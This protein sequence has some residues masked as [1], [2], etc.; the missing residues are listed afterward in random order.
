[1]GQNCCVAAKDKTLPNNISHET[2]TYRNVRQSP[3]WNFRW[4]NRTH[5]E[6]I[7]ENHARC[8]HNNS[9]NVTSEV[10]SVAD[11]ESDGLSDSENPH[12]AFQ[13]SQWRKSPRIG[14]S[15]NPKFIATDQS[16]ACNL[17][18]EV[19]NSLKS[20]VFPNASDIESSTALP[21]SSPPPL[22]VEDP[23]SSTSGGFNP[24][25][26]NSSRKSIRSPGFQLY[27]QISDSR[28]P[29]LKSLN[30]GSSSPEAGRLS[31]V[32]GN[33]LSIE[34]HGV[35]SD[36]WSMHTFS[37]LIAS[38]QRD[39]SSLTNENLKISELNSQPK[40]NHA[41]NPQT[42]GI[43]SKLLKEKSPWSA[44]K[45]VSTN[46]LPI[47]AVLVCGHVFHAECLESSTSETDMYDPPC[48]VC[49]NNVERHE[50]RGRNRI[51]RIV[52]VDADVDSI[53]DRRTRSG[54]GPFLGV[55]SSMKNSLSKQFSGRGPFLGASSSMKS[56][57]GKPFL[58]RHLSM[59]SASDNEKTRKKWFWP[60][61][62][63]E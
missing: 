2:S 48:H 14:G 33:E 30:E 54:K 45:I 47:A 29:S 11:A 59:H 58:K 63:R 43:C 3:S 42:C 22:K 55:S 40:G 35:S 53:S 1:M 26:P 19:N 39:R 27:R 12:K 51:S 4:D 32:L 13:T 57:F 6:D 34:S 10:K 49:S 15:D 18:S 46:D 28:I 56:S 38:S 24:S 37:E 44:Q 50:P 8:S 52:V 5:I 36:G 60:R 7:M 21:Y 61:Y 41:P 9:G 20:S 23:S 17:S 16:T 62:L 31:F 25:D